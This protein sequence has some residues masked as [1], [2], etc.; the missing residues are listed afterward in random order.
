MKSGLAG[1]EDFE[2]DHSFSGAAAVDDAPGAG[3]IWTGAVV[4][5]ARFGGG[6]LAAATVG[7]HW[8]LPPDAAPAP[9]HPQPA[10]RRELRLARCRA[11]AS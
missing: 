5:G 11:P 3:A 8:S 7:A 2:H 9:E 6:F 10:P 4:A 1:C